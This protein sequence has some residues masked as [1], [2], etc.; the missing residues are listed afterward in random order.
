MLDG[1]VFLSVVEEGMRHVKAAM[2]QNPPE[3]EDLLM[4]F[5]RTDSADRLRDR[6]R[7]HC[8]PPMFTPDL[9]KGYQLVRRLS[10]DFNRNRQQ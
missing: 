9:C 4:Y 3:V 5:D 6:I 10:N 8:V 1:L 2:P 7:L